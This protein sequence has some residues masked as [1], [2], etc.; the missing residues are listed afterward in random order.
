MKIQPVRASCFVLTNGWTNER[1]DMTKIIVAFRNFATASKNLG[2]P[3]LLLLA[4]GL[5]KRHL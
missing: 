3:S 5:T 2:T 1:K 4:A